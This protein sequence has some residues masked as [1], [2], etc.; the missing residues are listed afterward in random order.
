MVLKTIFKYHMSAI[1]SFIS[2]NIL[3]TVMK[4]ALHL[5]LFMLFDT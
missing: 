1:F 2:S 4:Q 5:D 3:K